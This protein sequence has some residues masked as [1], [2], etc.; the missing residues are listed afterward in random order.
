MRVEDN[1][2][3]NFQSTPKSQGQRRI[4]FAVLIFCISGNL[5]FA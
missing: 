1:P 2:Q 5:N 4:E 3:M